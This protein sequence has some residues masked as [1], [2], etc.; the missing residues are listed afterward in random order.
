MGILLHL[1]SKVFPLPIREENPQCN[2]FGFPPVADLP[3]EPEPAFE[4]DRRNGWVLWTV[5]GGYGLRLE[6]GPQFRELADLF[7]LNGWVRNF[8]ALCDAELALSD[9]HPGTQ[10]PPRA[11]PSS[12][13]VPNHGADL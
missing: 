13:S 3:R 9:V 1:P 10:A 8:N 4:I 11:E 5:N 7:A 6:H 12:G 2:A